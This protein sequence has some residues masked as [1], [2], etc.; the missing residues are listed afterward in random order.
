MSKLPWDTLTCSESEYQ[1]LR[2]F[3]GRQPV[4]YREED[5]EEWLEQATQVLDEWD[6][7]ETHKNLRITKSLRSPASEAICNLKLSKKV[8]VAQNY[9][10]I[11][12]DVFGHTEKASDLLYQFEHIN[13]NK[14]KKSFDYVRCLDKILHQ[15]LLKKGLD[16]QELDVVCAQQVLRGAQSLNPITILLRTRQHGDILKYPDL[17]RIVQEKEAMLEIKKLEVDVRVRVVSVDGGNSEVEFLK[18]QVPQLMERMTGF[19]GQVG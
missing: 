8:C 13:Q 12:Q 19:L 9:L 18:T 4:P 10:N 1:K 2:P 16:P 3:S 11:L 6:I 15:L 5:F 17:T 7:H 14:G